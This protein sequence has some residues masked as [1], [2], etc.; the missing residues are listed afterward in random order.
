MTFTAFAIAFIIF[1]VS[2]IFN[3]ANKA[4]QAKFDGM[5]HEEKVEWAKANVAKTIGILVVELAS[6]PALLASKATFKSLDE[7]CQTK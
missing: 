3:E 2:G 5:S 6:I 7:V 1:F 4:I